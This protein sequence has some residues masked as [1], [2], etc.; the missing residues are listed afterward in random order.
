M[1]RISC[2]SMRHPLVVL[3]AAA[4]TVSAANL[5]QPLHAGGSQDCGGNYSVKVLFDRPFS[6]V[7]AQF[8]SNSG[9]E[10]PSLAS[11]SY[12]A[13]TSGTLGAWTVSNIDLVS[14]IF[15]TPDSG[16]Q[17]LDMNMLSP[18]RIQQT[19]PTTAGQSVLLQLS[20]SYNNRSLS[21]APVMMTQ[22]LWNGIAIDTLQY[23]SNATPIWKRI[24]IPLVA[25][26]TDILVFQSINQGDAGIT[27]DDITVT[28]T[29]SSAQALGNSVVTLQRPDG[30][31]LPQITIPNTAITFDAAGTTAVIPLGSLTANSAYKGT[32]TIQVSDGSG[33]FTTESVAVA[34]SIGPWMDSVRIATNTLGTTTDSVYFWTSDPV[35]TSAT[36]SFLVDRLGSASGSASTTVPVTASL[37]NASS[38][39]Y[40]AVLPAGQLRNG[41]SLRLNPATTSDLHDNA[42]L[43]CHRN[44]PLSILSRTLINPARRTR[45]RT[46]VFWDC[47]AIYT[48]RVHFDKPFSSGSAQMVD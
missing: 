28:S 45:I 21:P 42:A 44:V 14:S 9:F 27:L 25:K 40:R 31:S 47:G 20:Y 5:P 4:T 26:G 23:A 11:S 8:A 6:S 1:R 17:A 48:A 30:T 35:T 7:A 38:H 39:E 29:T 43:D 3:I 19:L 24:S 22:I 12:G 10:A 36:W 37:V 2:R 41:D 32:M 46:G 18:G 33:T 13:Y 34:D 16:N 15:L